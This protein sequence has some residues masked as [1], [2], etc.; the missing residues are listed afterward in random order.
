MEMKRIGVIGSGQMG[1]GIAQ[2]AAQSSYEVTL[3]DVQAASLER[4]LKT[5][6]SSCD[7]LIKKSVLTEEAKSQILSK[8]KTTTKMQFILIKCLN[9][10]T[11]FFNFKPIILYVFK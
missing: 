1:S 2:V 8:I 5:I 9:L 7:R 4:A 10:F 3:M 11:L 6:T